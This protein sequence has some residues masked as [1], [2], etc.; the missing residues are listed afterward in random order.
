M[1][2]DGK[3]AD[4]FDCRIH[5]ARISIHVRKRQAQPLGS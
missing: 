3:V 1:G 2:D 5:G 4:I